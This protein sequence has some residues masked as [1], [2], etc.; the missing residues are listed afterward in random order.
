[1]ERVELKGKKEK[2][3]ERKTGRGGRRQGEKK[4]KKTGLEEIH[5]QVKTKSNV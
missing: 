3:G 4:K 1:L 2:K 5:S